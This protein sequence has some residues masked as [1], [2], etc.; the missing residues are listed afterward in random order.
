MKS[1]KEQIGSSRLSF[2]SAERLDRCLKLTQG[3]VSPFGI[4]NDK[5]CLVELVFDR[6][7]IGEKAVGFHPN[8]N[9]ATVWLSFEDLIKV[10]NDNGN[11]IH[12]VNL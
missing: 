2:G 3:S 7:L 1:V 4:L 12:Y 8:I 5:D 9:T 11:T 6:D 10:I